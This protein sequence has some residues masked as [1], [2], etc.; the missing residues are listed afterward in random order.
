MKQ[1]IKQPTRGHNSV[2][3]DYRFPWFSPA[4]WLTVVPSRST[5][6]LKTHKSNAIAGRTRPRW[7]AYKRSAVADCTALIGLQT[8]QLLNTII[9]TQCT[10]CHTTVAIQYAVLS[11]FLSYVACVWY[12]FTGSLPSRFIVNVRGLRRYL[13]ALIS[14]SSLESRV[15][16]LLDFGTACSPSVIGEVSIIYDR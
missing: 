13:E 8:D 6:R 14:R 1:R 4:S 5:W 15:C 2:I 3:L 7:P 11:I 10:L 12:T 9:V 16:M